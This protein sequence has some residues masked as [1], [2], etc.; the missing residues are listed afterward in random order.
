MGFFGEM[1]KIQVTDSGSSNLHVPQREMVCMRL[2]G[3]HGEE[4]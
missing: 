1:E 2:V 3:G 4:T